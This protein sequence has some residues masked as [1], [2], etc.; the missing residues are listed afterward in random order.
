MWGYKLILLICKG[1][2]D[3]VQRCNIF[4]F[5]NWTNPCVDFF[6][7]PVFVIPNINLQLKYNIINET[8]TV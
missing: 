1:N 7:L 8:D 4:L 5:I 6:W 3:V 2:I